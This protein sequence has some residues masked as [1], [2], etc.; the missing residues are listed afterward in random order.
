MSLQIWHPE[1]KS[2]PEATEVRANRITNAEG[3][4]MAQTN[5]KN[6]NLLLITHLGILS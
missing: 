5:C 3:D 6:I 1:S 2:E 4:C